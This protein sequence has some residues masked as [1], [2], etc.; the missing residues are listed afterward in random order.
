MVGKSTLSLQYRLMPDRRQQIQPTYHYLLLETASNE[1]RLVKLMLKLPPLPK[2]I[3]EAVSIEVTLK[4]YA[5]DKCPDYDALSYTWGSDLDRQEILVNDEI[6]IISRNLFLV[7]GHLHNI[8][9]DRW[10]WIDAICIDQQNNR[11]KTTEVGRMQSIYQQAKQVLAWTGCTMGD[12][13]PLE[14]QG[15]HRDLIRTSESLLTIVSST[16]RG[17]IAATCPKTCQRPATIKPLETSSISYGSSDRAALGESKS[18]D[19]SPHVCP[20]HY[21]EILFSY[22][23]VLSVCASHL[24]DKCLR[25]KESLFWYLNNLL[26]HP[27]WRRIWILQEFRSAREVVLLS[28]E[29]IMTLEQFFR[30]WTVPYLHSEDFFCSKE[31]SGD[32]KRILTDL[33]KASRAMAPML[34]QS[35]VLEGQ[36]YARSLLELL[37]ATGNFKASDP[38]DRIYALLGVSNDSEQLGIL[39]NYSDS[40]ETACIKLTKALIRKYGTSVLSFN[41]GHNISLPSWCCDFNIPSHYTVVTDRH[42]E[43]TKFSASGKIS[44]TIAFNN[45]N[46]KLALSIVQI[47]SVNSLTPIPI[48]QLHGA[49]EKEV[50]QLFVDLKYHSS[51]ITSFHFDNGWLDEALFCIPIAFQ[52]LLVQRTGFTLH[53]APKELVDGYWKLRSK[54]KTSSSMTEDSTKT[55]KYVQEVAKRAPGKNLFSCNS[56]YL[57]LGPKHM[58][59]G[60][61]LVLIVGA[62]VPYI[63]R[64]K[65]NGSF[66]LIG[67]AYVHG[68][69]YGEFMHRDE[70]ALQQIVLE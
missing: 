51:K 3:L 10:I 44:P 36:D 52:K 65:K 38:R 13:G 8:R 19:K 43:N 23:E 18:R 6:M 60:D 37:R 50:Q 12:A 25:W 16:K 14:M 33:N 7:L 24:L 61:S 20:K 35:S 56:Q 55:Q 4:T 28:E 9:F 2:K 29:G 67:E 69:M 30:V 27:I 41:A 47:G 22:P 68:I 62:E 64:D 63:L 59:E 11:E 54:P 32:S 39:P 53:D 1:I 49:R 34:L 42:T 17:A 26:S 48:D 66:R 70:V 31:H 15:W 5:G 46:D 58:R 57:G 40:Y 21:F 45:A